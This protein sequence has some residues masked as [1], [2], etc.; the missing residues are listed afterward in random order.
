MRA[1]ILFLTV[2]ISV[3][4]FASQQSFRSWLTGFKKQAVASGITPAFFD[5]TF[6]GMTIGHRQIHF[7]RTQPERRLTFLKYRNKRADA[8]R[9]KLGRRAYKRNKDLLEGIGAKYGVDPC[10]IVSIWGLETSYGRYMGSFDVI[11]SLATLAYE[12]RR[13]TFFRKELIHALQILQAGQVKRKDF[14]GEWAGGSGHT[15][16]LPSSW[17]RYAVDHSGDGKRDI[18][19]NKSDALAS[20]ANY[21]SMNGW[22]YHAP[23]RVQVMLP[24]HFNRSLIGYKIKKP[25][26]V[27][28]AMGVHA[29]HGWHMPSQ[30]YQASIIRPHGGPSFMVFKNWRVIMTY[31]YSSFYAGTISYMADKI[32]RR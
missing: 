18:W 15:Q 6:R 20:I 7:D 1:I 30:N 21:L 24:Y 22:V 31:N 17:K 27:W 9:I 19:T 28:T 23:V 26:R 5:K 3:S 11:R 10:Y 29:A 4:G 12:G 13:A 8:Y 25:L 16:F 2:L 14:K 32:C